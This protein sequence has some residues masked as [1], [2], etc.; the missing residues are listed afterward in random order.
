MT[1]LQRERAVFDAA[2]G[3]WRRSH[4]GEFVLIHGDDVI[5]FY[6]SL[7]KAFGDGTARFGLDPFFVQRITPDEEVNV[8]F[9]GLGLTTG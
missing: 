6:D 5:G 1:E 4:S 8:S 9:F 7:E 3:E 2:I